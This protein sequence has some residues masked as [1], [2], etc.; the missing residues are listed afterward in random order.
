M[1]QEQALC[2]IYFDA[3]IGPNIFYCNKNLSEEGKRPN[4][5]RLLEFSDGE[6]TFIYAFQKYQTIN[7][8]FYLT[9]PY[10]R[11]GKEILMISYLIKAASFKNEI[12]DVFNYLQSKTPILLEFANKL[13]TLEDFPEVLHKNI[14]MHLK[15]NLFK[16]G[17]SEFQKN[18]FSLFNTIFNK[19]AQIIQ[20]DLIHPDE[21]IK[22]VFIFGAD[23]VGK[24]NFL[25]NIEMIQL[26]LQKNK[27]IPTKIFQVVIDNL[28]ILKEECIKAGLKCDQCELNNRCINYAEGFIVI[29]DISNKSSIIEAKERFNIIISK[30]CQRTPITKIPMLLIGNKFNYHEEFSSKII[31]K[32]FQTKQAK[33]CAIDIQYFTMDLSKDNEKV[34]DSLR[35]LI[36]KMI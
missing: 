16:L 8:T 10:A 2:I 14:K 7:H 27:D 9:S 25:K 1:P 5:E 30:L 18:F 32:T 24:N 19:L 33:K 4:F 11:G 28:E 20:S 21:S 3:I 26:N 17:N 15:E 36:R 22:K 13:K 6:G 29:F 12:S 34:L 23:H 35:W 31:Y